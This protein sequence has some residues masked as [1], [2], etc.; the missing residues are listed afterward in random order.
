VQ[1]EETIVTPDRV[2]IIGAA[3]RDFHN[4][5][6]TLAKIRLTTEKRGVF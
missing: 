6:W 4:F 2:L 3:G 5:N 1:Q